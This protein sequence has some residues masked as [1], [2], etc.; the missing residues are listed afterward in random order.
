M[1][2]PNSLIPSQPFTLSYFLTDHTDTGTYFV[3]AVIYDATTG[4]VLDTQN[5]TKQTT[6]TRLFSK[7]TNAPGDS[8]GHGR[9]II[10]VATAYD[11]SGYTIKSS[12]YQEQSE[13]YIVIRAGAGLT[14]G[15]G[16]VDY[17]VIKE[18][19]TTELKTELKKVLDTHSEIIKTLHMVHSL[20]KGIP[21]D[22][23]D[24]KSITDNLTL[25]SSA[26]EKIPLDNSV[27]FSSV[28]SK[29]DEAIQAI[30]D[31][32]V[33]QTTDL[34]ALSEAISELKDEIGVNHTESKDLLNEHM[35]DLH[36][37]LPKIVQDNTND[38]MSKANFSMP[39]KMNMDKPEEKPKFDIRKLTGQD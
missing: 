29:V 10:V 39:F 21:T 34:T 12:L 6:N 25:L 24:L 13:N 20:I 38:V 16:G 35:S 19:F 26:I 37:V 32:E 33:T 23:Y 30:T 11:D 14:L 31:K 7:R 3:R 17:N 1:Q 18:I 36:T 9:R 27:D 5:L 8:S 15:G 28:L 4:E 22:K 2:S